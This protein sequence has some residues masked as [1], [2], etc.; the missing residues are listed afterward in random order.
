MD[1]YPSQQFIGSNFVTSNFE[2]RTRP[3]RL[4]TILFGLAG[5]YDAGDA[6]DD[7][8]QI[9]PKHS[10]GL[11]FRGLFPQ[12]QRIVGRLECAFPLDRPIVPGQHWGSVDVLLTVEGQ[13][14]ATPQLVS[15][16]SPLLTPA[17]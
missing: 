16:G 6:F 10:V 3:L 4:W 2:I 17:D 5:F 13:P 12:F 7:W 8:H 1:G 9:R 14:F 11:G 15:R